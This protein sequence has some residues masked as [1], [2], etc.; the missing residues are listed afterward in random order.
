[1]PILRGDTSS[2]RSSRL[3]SR[4][5]W[6]AM[7]PMTLLAGATLDHCAKAGRVTNRVRFVGS[8]VGAKHDSSTSDWSAVVYLQASDCSGNLSIVRPLL[9]KYR[10]RQISKIE[11]VDVSTATDLHELTVLLPAEL[12]SL[13]IRKIRSDERLTIQSLGFS[14][15]PLVLL[16]DG[17]SRVRMAIP[18]LSDPSERVATNRAISHIVLGDP[19]R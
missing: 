4:L 12:R 7:I 16:R 6:L 1:M 11:L 17:D 10:T 18:T 2:P 15:T 19:S 5:L 9:A 14:E 13:P 3:G 8:D